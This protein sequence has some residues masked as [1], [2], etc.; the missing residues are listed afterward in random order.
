MLSPIL[1]YT[2]VWY[3]SYMPLSGSDSYDNTGAVYDATKIIDSAGKFLPK[4]YAEYSPIFMPVTFALGYGISFAIMSC[5][6]VHIFLYYH[7]EIWAL[8]GAGR[9]K[10]FMPGSWTGT[11][12]KSLGGG[13]PAWL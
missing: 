6:P 10:M 2:N 7:K 4:A 3:T 5:V 9:R 12:R 8:S 11:T 13:M 1:Y